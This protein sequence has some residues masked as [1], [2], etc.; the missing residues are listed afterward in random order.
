V[1]ATD[2]IVNKVTE[3]VAK[4]IATEMMRV[5]NSSSMQ[6]IEEGL[7]KANH[8]MQTMANHQVMAMAPQEIKYRYFAEVFDII[9]EQSRNKKLC[10]QLEN[11]E[12]AMHMKSLE[13][14]KSD[15]EIQVEK[16]KRDT[17]IQL[18]QTVNDADKV[19]DSNNIQGEP[20]IGERSDE[21]SLKCCYP[22]CIF[23][24]MP[25]SPLLD[26]CQG[27]CGQKGQFHHACNVNWLESKGIDAELRKICYGCVVAQYSNI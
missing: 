14:D 13:K 7:A 27:M 11:E 12:M 4:A 23:A 3:G 17:E 24:N 22:E 5:D 26:V 25:T 16:E 6:N 21:G 15:M 10:L 18:G 9:N 2:F 19:M 1:K 8:I 20:E